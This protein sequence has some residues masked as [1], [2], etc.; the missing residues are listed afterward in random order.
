MVRCEA[1]LVEACDL[2]DA[3]RSETAEAEA[4]GYPWISSWPTM[5]ERSVA[6]II[7]MT[8]SVSVIGASDA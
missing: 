7:R 5:P 6:S 8:A 4:T 2:R 1:E 3:G